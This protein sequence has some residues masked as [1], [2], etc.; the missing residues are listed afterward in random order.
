LFV[1]KVLPIKLNQEQ[2]SKE[3]EFH[4]LPPCEKQALGAKLCQLD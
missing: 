3:V 4:N 2:F 1:G